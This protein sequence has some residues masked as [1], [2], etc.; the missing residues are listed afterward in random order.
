MRGARRTLRLA[1]PPAAASVMA[2][3]SS[4]RPARSSTSPWRKSPPAG[5]MLAPSAAASRTVSLSPLRSV[6]SWMTTASAPFGTLAPVKMRA[7]SPA[8]TVPANGPPALDSPM[9]RNVDRHL[10]DIGRAHRIAVHGGSVERRLR[11][12]RGDVLGQHALG[13]AEQVDALGA[14]R[15]RAVEHAPQRLV[16][17]E[18]RHLSAP[19]PKFAGARGWDRE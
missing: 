5:R 3:A 9:T 19:I 8:P 4:S 2:E 10:A 14:E 16:D 18:Q 15:R 12:L 17:G 1:W 11:Q 13:R 6:S 7:A